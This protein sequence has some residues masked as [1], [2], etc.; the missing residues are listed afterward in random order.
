MAGR[1]RGLDTDGGRHLLRGLPAILDSLRAVVAG[2]ADT[3]EATDAELVQCLQI[4]W[5][6]AERWRLENEA[7]PRTR[8]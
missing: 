4:A 2:Y 7:S 3:G 6:A 8:E 1:N 5:V